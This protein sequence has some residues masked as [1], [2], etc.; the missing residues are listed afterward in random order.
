M[1]TRWRSFVRE[2]GPRSRSA[3][4]LAW[5]VV[6]AAAIGLPMAAID[7]LAERHLVAEAERGAAGWARHIAANVPD[8]DL[9]F[10]GEEA[11]TR[12]QDQLASMRGMAGLF[13]FKFF[14]TGGRLVLVSD[15]LATP[16]PRGDDE[17]EV[18][19]IALAVA[20][21]GRAD[22]ALKQGDGVRRPAVYSEA[23]VPV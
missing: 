7:H 17:G 9:V 5:L 3:V 8:L 11:T 1:L 2:R 10:M 23:Y 19:A 14:D 6:V 18:N 13:R 16:A 15:S 20:R 21:G 4:A 22:I 12:A